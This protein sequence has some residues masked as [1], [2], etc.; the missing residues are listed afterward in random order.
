VAI[1]RCD[2][3]GLRILLGLALLMATWFALTPSPIPLPT[4]FF[5]DKWAHLATYLLLAFLV[6]ASWPETGF[7]WRKWAALVGYGVSIELIQSLIP[8]RMFSLADVV[9]NIAGIAL[10]AFLVLPMLRARSIR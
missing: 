1:S 6:D 8:N 2:C 7:D 9:A 4:D 3:A 10:Y 5:A